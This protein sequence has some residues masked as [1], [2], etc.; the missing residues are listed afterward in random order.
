[1]LTT[2]SFHAALAT[3]R[4]AHIPMS[5][6]HK[7]LISGGGIAGL[8]TALALRQRGVE[9]TVLEQATQLREVGA[10][11]QISP[12]GSRVLQALGLGAAVEA[13]ACEAA[14]KE[15]RLWNTG[16]RWPLFDLGADAR[17]RFGAPYWM[18]HRGD[19]H[20]VLRAAFEAA[21]PGAL[22][23]GVRVEHAQTLG[24]GVHV[25]AADGRVFTADVMVAADGVHSA[26]RR[27]AFGEGSARFTGLMAWRGVVP[28]ARLAPELCAPVGV[29][30]VGPG[31]HVITYPL[32]RGE[33]LN[34][35]AIVE[36]PAWRGESWSD[37][38]TH[39][40]VH[41]DLAGWHPDLHHLID[42]MELPFRWALL[43]RPAL[44]GWLDGRSVLIGDAAHP[45]LPFLAQ[46]ANMALE[47]ALLLAR[48]LTELDDAPAALA[49]FVALR[50]P[51]TTRIVQGAADNTHRFHNPLLAD[52]ATAAAYID[53]EWE[54]TRVR[55]RYDWLFE[56]D[57]TQLPL[58]PPP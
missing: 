46:G 28:T 57:V 23:T 5:S 39:D 43:S 42:A 16:R 4:S 48:C 53:R 52:P 50:L 19:L 56:H 37:A 17:S 10:G 44:T 21:A 32:R 8:A 9:V 45:T 24:D 7:V 34:V 13:L 47:D 35:V 58:D 15:V 31:G 6:V 3:V 51:R 11:L 55:Q 41:H 22:Q 26:Q 27:A 14:A 2:T 12:N 40:E 25:T 1:M 18:L 29:N 49:R 30:W 36:K 54:P 33:L 20:Q 38:G